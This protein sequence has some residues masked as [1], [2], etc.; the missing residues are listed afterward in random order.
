[1]WWLG[2]PREGIERRRQAYALYSRRGEKLA[3]A[4]LA[5]YLAAEHRIAGE[6][7][8]AAGWLARAERLGSRS[9][10]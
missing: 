3:A 1:M 4:N 9:T 8:A 5:T 2:Q 6:S 7:A 10:A